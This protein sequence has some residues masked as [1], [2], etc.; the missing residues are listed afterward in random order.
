M[1]MGQ[2]MTNEENG[3]DVDKVAGYLKLGVILCAVFM[4]CIFIITPIIGSYNALVDSDLQ[5]TRAA[6]NIKVDLERRADLLP[7]LAETVKGSATFEYKTLV[8]VTLARAGESTKIKKHI[9]DTPASEVPN[10]ASDQEQLTQILGNFV[11]LQE[12]YP[13]LQTTQQFREF[14]AQVTATENEIL[15]DRQTYNAAVMQYQSVVRIF[16]SNLISGYFGFKADKYKMYEPTDM[17]RAETVP[18]ITFD[19]SNL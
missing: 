14:S 8:D 5:V 13:T 18:D 12:Q 6:S 11:K 4:A 3:I 2:N 15:A 7:N 17:T 10:L 9:S 16:P 1:R 19:F